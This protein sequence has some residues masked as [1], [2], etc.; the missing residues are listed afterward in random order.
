MNKKELAYIKKNFSDD[1]SNKTVIITG[2][3]SGIGFESAKYLCYLNA[4]VIIAVRSLQRGN[5]AIKKIK[6][7]IPQAK[8]SL[9]ELDM[10][11]ENSIK[12]FVSNIVKN[13]I[14]VDI[15]YHNAGVYRLP[16][17]IVEDKDIITGTNYYG[18]IIL[19]SL[20]LPYLNSLKHEVKMI[21]TSSL[22]AMW[23][24]YKYIDLLP[25]EKRS[26]IKRYSNSKLLDAYLFKYLL[27]NEHSNI[28]YLL[29]HPGVANTGLI[30]KAYKN[31]VFLALMNFAMLFISNPIWK[32]SLSCL[33]A[34]KEETPAGTFYG[35]NHFFK[36]LG[37]P[38][39]CK[40]LNKK[41]V[42]LDEIINESEKIVGYKLIA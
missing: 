4:N 15:F 1:I 10:S 25:N 23:T 35:P 2:G 7:E 39:K 3:N 17:E 8:I 34:I 41:Y 36:F 24:S 18:E 42:K 11:H 40:F 33:M 9:M 38:K 37:Y 12:E 5:E 20:L 28:K 6:D 32:S 19:T 31:K 21:F 16:F 22:A 13:K 14:D 29:V 30:K 26:K 27:D